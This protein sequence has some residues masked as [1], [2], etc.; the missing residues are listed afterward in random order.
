MDLTWFDPGAD[1]APR[2]DELFDR[3]APLFAGVT[4]GRG[5]FFNLGWLIDLVTE[6]RGDPGQAIPTR[7]RRTAPWAA[8][9]YARL[10][11]FVAAYRD[12]AERHGL[13]GLGCGILFVEWAHVVW[14]PELKIYDF[15]SDWYDRHPELYEP[16]RSFINMPDLHPVN[17]LRGD[18]YPYASAPG[19]IVEG[20]SFATFFGRQ[21]ADFAR[22][23]GFD[24][25][26]LR[27]GFTGPMIYTRNG[28]YGTRAPADPEQVARFSDAVRALY[29][30]VKQAAPERLVVGYSSAISPV[31]DWRVGCV[32]FESLVADGHIDAW[33]EQ[34][35][36]GAWQDWWHQLWKGW[37]FQT[38]NLLT[39][40][41]MIAA[42]NRRRSSPCA[43]WHLVET[44]DGWEHWDTL[45]QVPGKLTWG[46]WAFAHASALTPEGP[47]P[48]DGVYVSWLNNGAME[49]L[50][51]GDVLFLR[52]LLDRAELSAAALEAVFGPALVYDRAAMEHLATT[53]PDA[54]VA[55]WI[56][57][58]AGLLMKWGVPVLAASRPEWL[59]AL[60]G[61]A[62]G[63]QL[64]SQ[65]PA[66]SSAAALAGCE[67]VAVFGDAGAIAPDVAA[68]L[69][70]RPTGERIE[71]EFWVCHDDAGAAP[72]F[73]RPYFPEHGVVAV[74]D[75]VTVHYA[76]EHTPLVTTRAGRLWWQ[77]TDWSE[78]F[79]QFLPKYQLGSTYP[80]FLVASLL[81]GQA[82][83]DG[84]SHAVDVA[85]PAPVAFHLWRSGGSVHVLLGN[86]ETGELGDSRVPRRVRIRLS[87][88]ELGL[89]D[90]PLALR[91]IDGSGPDL[92]PTDLV[93]S[94]LVEA[95]LT[96]PPESAAVY[97][98]AADDR[99]AT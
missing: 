8:V 51:P 84:R 47:R 1:F 16:P 64:I 7:S 43:L 45:H 57:D 65:P 11:E 59:G 4:G 81:S 79:N 2:L 72:P 25:I 91:R 29:R 63:R 75:D 99:G 83:A 56:D 89:P 54:N 31:A 87:T 13:P 66:P 35:W 69:G 21:W 5:I 48:S 58:Q 42:A 17:A 44:W 27:D 26:L 73:D 97:V 39:R 74:D 40:G 94:G 93:E 32:D 78:P 96:L 34:T 33:I 9:T 85:R 77:P 3:I 23:T 67:D 28:P 19:G 62:R 41:A 68:A 52:G 53:R 22:F 71:A 12:A 20:T 24:A 76:S 46:A 92:V 49:L 55:E 30:E 80:A 86:L 18:D 88:T 6:W 61:E 10:R 70:V 90:G 82:V 50:A 36:A 15:D 38:A 37:T 98:V 14:P 95:A 60:D